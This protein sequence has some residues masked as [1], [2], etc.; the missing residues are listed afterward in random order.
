MAFVISSHARVRGARKGPALFGVA[1]LLLYAGTVAAEVSVETRA[2]YVSVDARNATVRSILEA[3]ADARIVDVTASTPLHAE[4]TLATGPE[5]LARL[6]RRL[7]R[8]YSYTLIEHDPSSGRLPR[9]HVFADADPG[10]RVAW[11]ARSTPGADRIDRAIAELADPD[12]DVCEEAV[13]TLSDSGDP[14]AVTH[15]L[16][17]LSDPSPDVREAARAALEDMDTAIPEGYE[18]AASSRHGD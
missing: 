8:R 13:L 16:S 12:E 7:L 1:L 5:P 9:L 6:L 18:A 17:T 3:L 15:F 2:G 4:V 14:D 11:A 10:A